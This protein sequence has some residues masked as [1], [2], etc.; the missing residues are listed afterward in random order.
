MTGRYCYEDGF[1]I[2]RHADCGWCGTRFNVTAPGR[3][4]CDARCSQAARDHR[5]GRGGTPG[6]RPK[7]LFARRQAA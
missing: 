4:Y 1:A 3:R 6:K 2:L 5:R 7:L